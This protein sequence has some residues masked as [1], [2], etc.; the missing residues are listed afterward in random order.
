MV[1]TAGLPRFG[2]VRVLDRSISCLPLHGGVR[3]LGRRHCLAV[4][5]VM[6]LCATASGMTCW[7]L[8]LECHTPEGRDWGSERQAL[9]WRELRMWLE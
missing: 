2:G 3:G 4:S 9:M 7:S 6:G 1:F 5:F 8:P